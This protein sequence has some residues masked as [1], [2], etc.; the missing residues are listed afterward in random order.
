MMELKILSKDYQIHNFLIL[1]IVYL[2]TKIQF[3]VLEEKKLIVKG[4][5]LI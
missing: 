5:I 2:L 3:I 4:M 1:I